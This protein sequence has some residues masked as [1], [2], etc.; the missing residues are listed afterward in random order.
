[1][2]IPHK[3]PPLFRVVTC[4]C[5]DLKANTKH[6]YILWSDEFRVGGDDLK[7]AMA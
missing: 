4:H 6:R 3:R 1:M 7:P 2:A 5:L